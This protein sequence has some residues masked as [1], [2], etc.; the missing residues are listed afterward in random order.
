MSYKI[1]LRGDGSFVFAHHQNKPDGGVRVAA[2]KV[3]GHF[4]DGVVVKDMWED[5]NQKMHDHYGWEP[6]VPME[7]PSCA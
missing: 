2:H 1:E 3:D 6:Y 4:I 5:A 7:R